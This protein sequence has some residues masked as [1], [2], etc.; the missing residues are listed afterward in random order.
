V[1]IFRPSARVTDPHGREWEIYAFR[2]RLPERPPHG[3]PAGEGSFDPRLDLIAQAFGVIFW[4]M[5]GLLRLVFRI[6]VDL[7]VAAV[8]AL[9]SDEWTIEAVSWAPFQSRY[10]WTT[11][12]EYRGQVLAQVEGGLARGDTTPRPRNAHLV[13]VF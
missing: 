3:D 11:T 2:V 13:R 8:K 6:L 4:L 10:T 9:G 1:S 12:R 5:G 7:P